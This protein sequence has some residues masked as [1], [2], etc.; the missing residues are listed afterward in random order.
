VVTLEIAQGAS[1]QASAGGFVVLLGRRRPSTST[2]YSAASSGL[3][4]IAEQRLNRRY[5]ST[6]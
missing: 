4:V 5:A 2:A 1:E 6:H 3:D